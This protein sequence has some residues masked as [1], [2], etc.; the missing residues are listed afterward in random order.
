MLLKICSNTFKDLDEMDKFLE[1]HKLPKVTREKTD[2]VN[3]TVSMKEM[4]S[5]GNSTNQLKK[6]ENQSYTTIPGTEGHTCSP[7]S[8]CSQKTVETITQQTTDWEKIFAKHTS[9]KYSELVEH[10]KKT[11]NPKQKRYLS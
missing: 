11:S 2:H 3:S 4:A 5:L 8:S 10:D 6:K 1:G 9:D 7:N